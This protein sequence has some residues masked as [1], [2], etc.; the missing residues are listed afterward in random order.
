MTTDLSE[1]G[2]ESMIVEYLTN[3]NSFELGSNQDYDKNYAVDRERLTRFLKETQEKELSVTG[4]FNNSQKMDKFIERLQHEIFRRGIVD[5]LRNGIGFHPVN[6]VALYYSTPTKGNEEA[7][8]KYAANIFS[9][10][11]QLRYS[12]DQSKLALDLC[13]FLNGL[14][15]Y[16]CELKNN[17]TNQCTEDA[18]QQYKNDRNPQ[19][20]LFRFKKCIA[21]F[22]IDDS[23]VKY[24]TELKGKNSYFLPFNKG[25]NNRGGN[26]PNP[27]GL[28]TDYMWKFLFTKNGISKIIE[29]YAQIIVE[30]R[31]GKQIE[32]QIFPRYHQLD[33]VENLLNSLQEEKIGNKYLIQHSAGSGKSNSIAW[34][35]YQLVNQHDNPDTTFDSII[36]ITDRVNLDKQIRDTI[37][38]FSQIP[39]LVGWAKASKDLK[40]FL[41]SG[42]KIIISTI[43]KFKE[44][45]DEIKLNHQD[46]KFAIIIDEAHSSQGGTL[47]AKMNLALSEEYT[48]EDKDYEDI[49][50]DIIEGRKMLKN[51]NYYAF[52]ATPKSKTLELFGKRYQDG[53]KVKFKPY[54]V[55]SMKQAIDEGFILDVLKNY[56]PV[57][58]YYTLIKTVEDDPEFDVM[59]A[60]K[61]LRQY[62]GLETK[63]IHKKAKTIVDHFHDTIIK[64][65]KIGGKARAMVVTSGIIQAIEYY[66]AINYYLN[67]RN[68]PYKAIIAFSG[69]KEYCGKMVSESTFNGFPS[70]L[71]EKKIVQDPYRILV[72]ADKFQTGYDEPLLHT[73][74]V[75]KPLSDVKAVQ[76]LSRLNRSCPGKYDTCVLDFADNEE[77]INAAFEEYSCS[78][79]LDG[80]TDPNKLYDFIDELK[81]YEVFTKEQVDTV[82]EAYLKNYG[83]AKIDY[84]LDLCREK[85]LELDS[86]KQI[87]FKSLSK[88]YVRTYG[89]LSSI[90]TFGNPEWEKYSLFLAMLVGKLPSPEEDDSINKLLECVD[91]DSYRLEVKNAVTISLSEEDSFITPAP[92]DIAKRIKDPVKDKLS[93]ILESFNSLW[94]DLPWKDKDNVGRQISS[95]PAMVLSNEQYRNAISN[96]DKE[97]AKTE[98]DSALQNVMLSIMS[99]NMELYK[100]FCDNPDFKKWLEDLVF[101]TTY[102]QEVNSDGDN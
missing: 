40:G 81:Q 46:S 29:S 12:T 75:D 97:N 48:G 19:D 72:V 91:L 8:K 41:K 96:S 6:K 10:T 100:Q 84:Q 11:R 76:T 85:Y 93:V 22:A 71:I 66:E 101:S 73:M 80:E 54:H 15:I 17:L 28:K 65:C 52:T 3:S 95:I 23:T 39:G 18:V 89:F 5:V 14:P 2:L 82:V 32:K 92:T 9:V 26:P 30:E 62:I 16:T 43:H 83:R 63:P 59:K 58:S 87:L 70:E 55:Y 69:E 53:D 37:K 21:H 42:K 25:Y 45:V 61:K 77:A 34:L 79:N 74:Y 7:I 13:I 60:H 33:L 51:A 64:Q 88:K 50:N 47:S 38:N 24:C 1:F 27:D 4:I 94:G 56:V 57:S 44:I 49:I 102:A 35:T 86:E 36:V 68:S 78:T 90:L 31:D 99:D 98:S 67:E 20:L